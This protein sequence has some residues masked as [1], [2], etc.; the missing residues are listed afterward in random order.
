VCEGSN[1]LLQL[2]LQPLDDDALH[3]SLPNQFDFK[4]SDI[5]E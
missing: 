4:R 1:E 2:H 3:P 5:P